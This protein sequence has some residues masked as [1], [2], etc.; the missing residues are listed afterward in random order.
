VISERFRLG[1]R[2]NDLAAAGLLVHQFDAMD[3]PNP[4]GEPWIPGKGKWDTGDR[5]SA[6]LVNK[7]MQ[8]E[9]NG[10]IPVYSY[11]LAGIIL[12]PHANRLLC[13]YPFDSGSIE[14]ACNPRGIS[15]QCTPGCTPA[16][17]T[18]I[19]AVWCE[20]FFKDPWPCAWP[21]DKVDIMM[22]IRDGYASRGVK[23][24]MKFWD[25]G[26]FY[27][28]LILDQQVYTDGLPYSV[29][30]F[31]FVPSI[32]LDA[33]DGPKCQDYA[34]AAHRNFLVAFN[35]TSAEVPL[36]R[37]DTADWEHPFKEYSSS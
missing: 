21:P 1:N 14:R 9:P 13:S 24:G 11:S 26:K 32:C 30:A 22:E 31:F 34:I 3:D 20:G 17:W 4:D 6:S 23:P 19:P 16:G 29:S 7:N 15:D 2:S 5:I 28:E 25:D 36:L 33:Y 12:N 37:F 10:N 8:P 27:S 35:I 18:N